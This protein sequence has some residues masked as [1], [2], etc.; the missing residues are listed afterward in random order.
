[1]KVVTALRSYEEN[2]E[3]V[4]SMP[5]DS[6]GESLELTNVVLKS[7]QDAPVNVEEFQE[8]VGALA[9]G[10]GEVLERQLEPYLYGR[11]ANPTD[12]VMEQTKSAPKHN[13]H[14]ERTLAM[15]DSQC[16]RA[17]NAKIDFISSKVRFRMNHAIDW[18]EK[19]ED[20]SSVLKFAINKGRESI[21]KRKVRDEEVQNEKI[22]RMKLKF[23]KKDSKVRRK[24]Q[25][26]AEDIMKN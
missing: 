4:L 11:L 16:R 23:Q 19:Q 18:L 7:L 2:P 12:E 20:A 22:K 21:N 26:K 9:K 8:I 1:M 17:P 13:I 24:F 25:G 5:I 15:A 6:F 3:I 14:S 10:F